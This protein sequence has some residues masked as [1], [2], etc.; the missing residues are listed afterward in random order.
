MI[1]CVNIDWLEVH[2]LEDNQR[3]PCNAEFFMRDGW[4]IIKRDYGTRVY[5][6]MFT[7]KDKDGQPFIEI[8]RQPKSDNSISGILDPLSCHIRLVNRYCYFDNAVDLLR[9][10]LARYNYTF[11]RIFRIDICLDFERF[12]L[13]DYPQKFV[14]RYL[15]HKF[16]KINQCNRTT[17][18]RDSWDGC[19]DN[20]LSWGNPK[21]MVS[22]KMYNKSLE[23]KEV[24]DKPYIR[25]AWWRCG[26]IDNPIRNTK[27]DKDGHEYSP[28]IWRVEFS[29]HAGSAGWCIIEDCNGNKRK[30]KTM[31]HNLSNYDT[32]EKI[33]MIF[34]SLAHHYFHFKYYEEG[35]RKDRCR[36]KVL[37]NWK[38]IDQQ[39]YKL[40][41]VAQA[42]QPAHDDIVLKRRLI[43]YA[44]EHRDP[45]LQHA[46]EII[47]KQMDNDM[48]R[49]L[50]QN[51]WSNYDF[52]FNRFF[53][54][55]RLENPGEDWDI[56]YQRVREMVDAIAHERAF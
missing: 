13:G 50:S 4:Q 56:A 38:F 31:E 16:S 3:Y 25:Q 5:E 29:I 33:L 18:G 41:R 8:R 27:L 39:V 14:A 30:L 37:F 53:M 6:E 45:K 17:R 49:T 19:E 54:K 55:E 46:I 35:K 52:L 26:L 40:D 9:Q 7:L 23:L 2:V 11:R 44:Q 22:T 43:K 21:S 12:D 36:D 10:F 42:E 15:A 32:R 28:E 24:H 51:K 1:R 20:Y 48:L 47:I 34:Q